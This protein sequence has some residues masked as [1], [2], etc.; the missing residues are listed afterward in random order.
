MRIIEAQAQGSL[1]Q[2]RSPKANSETLRPTRALLEAITSW[3]SRNFDLPATSDV[4]QIEFLSGAALEE[5]RHRG[6]IQDQEAIASAPSSARSIDRRGGTVALYDGE[7]R[8]IYLTEA[9][10]GDTAAEVSILVHEMVHH[11]QQSGDMRFECPQD[12]ERVAYEAQE[13][14]LTLSG[15]SL[16]QDFEIDPLTLLLRTNCFY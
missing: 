11:L 7:R 3:L 16:L 8:T 13:R 10:R 6:S 12:R 5:M 9:W 4:P 14:W 1:S 15:R 2:Q